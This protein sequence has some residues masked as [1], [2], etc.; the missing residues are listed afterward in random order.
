MP[1]PCLLFAAAIAASA[2]AVGPTHRSRPAW[3]AAITST[4]ANAEP[5]RMSQGRRHAHLSLGRL[6][7]DAQARIVPDDRERDQAAA[8]STRRQGERSSP[9]T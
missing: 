8:R 9:R 5:P 6:A 7:T 1:A 4:G 2:P 3:I